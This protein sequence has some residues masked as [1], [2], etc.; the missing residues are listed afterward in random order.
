MDSLFSCLTSSNDIFR[1]DLCMKICSGTSMA[2][3]MAIT[4][5]IIA[6][7]EIIQSA[8]AAK[9]DCEGCSASMAISCMLL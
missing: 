2:A 4:S 6:T 8:R 7:P 5:S 9:A 1:R 3:T